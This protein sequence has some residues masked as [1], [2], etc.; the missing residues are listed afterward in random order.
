M[1]RRDASRRGAPAPH[2]HSHPRAAPPFRTARP[3]TPLHLSL[4]APSQHSDSREQLS[5]HIKTT[6]TRALYSIL[7]HKAIG[8]ALA[9]G[10]YLHLT[11]TIAGL[12]GH[13]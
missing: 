12:I 13:Q 9:L 4:R 1:P 10:A 11:S 8:A 3:H 7:L 6:A 5:G 2:A